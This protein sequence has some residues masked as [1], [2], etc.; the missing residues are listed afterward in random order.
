MILKKISCIYLISFLFFA[1]VGNGAVFAKDSDS[2]IFLKVFGRKKKASSVVIPIF[3]NGKYIGK[4]T[5]KVVF[6]K[7]LLEVEFNSI[8]DKFEDLVQLIISVK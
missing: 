3:S 6:N 2:D 1:F 4:T 7:T 8:K 5:C